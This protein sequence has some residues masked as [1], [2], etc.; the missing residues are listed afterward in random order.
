MA[1]AEKRKIVLKEL[2]RRCYEAGEERGQR[3]YL[4][5][6]DFRKASGYANFEEWFTKNIKEVGK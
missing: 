2:M 5:D 4:H 1:D 6:I 3:H